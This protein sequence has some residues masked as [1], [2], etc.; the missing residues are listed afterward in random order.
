MAVFGKNPFHA[1]LRE[2]ETFREI[3]WRVY[4]KH[5]AGWE[6]NPAKLARATCMADS[7]WS[8]GFMAHVWG[9][10]GDLLCIDPASGITDSRRLSEKY[11]DFPHLRWLG[12]VHGKTP[13]FSAAESGRWVCVESHIKLNTPGKKDGV[14]ELWVDG[15]PEAARTELDWHGTWSDYAINA[16]FLENYWNTGSVKRQSRW[17]DNFVVS[18]QPI[19]PIVATA[20]PTVT[21]TAG[22]GVT[23]WEAQAATDPEGKD[24]VWTSN[25]IYGAKLSVTVDAAH[26]KFTAGKAQLTPGVTHWL[27]LRERSGAGGWS[28]W[29]AWH[30]SFRILP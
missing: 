26:G 15:K 12:L 2:N 5:E 16:V 18:T 27:R 4:V 13:I 6:G 11:N 10:K 25:P 30:S 19:G 17:L 20:T 9:G 22:S 23:Q 28:G 8:Q 7:N 24:V 29:T 14:F 1:Q 21:R 3:Y